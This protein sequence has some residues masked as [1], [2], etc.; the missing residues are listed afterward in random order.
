[1]Y[2]KLY[3]QDGHVVVA[4]CDADLLGRTLAE[5][6]VRLRVSEEFYG[7][8]SVSPERLK[9]ALAEATTANLVGEQVVACAEEA[10]LVD[11]GSVMRIEGVPHAQ[12]FRV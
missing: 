8:E 10:G 7:G 5:G 11:A 9:E 2:L 6:R 4:A 12:I 3:R 1:M